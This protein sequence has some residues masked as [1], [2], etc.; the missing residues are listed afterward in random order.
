MSFPETLTDALA[1]Q[2]SPPAIWNEDL[3]QSSYVVS[4]D[5]IAPY[6][7]IQIGGVIFEVDKRDMIIPYIE[8]NEVQCVTSFV[9]SIGDDWGAPNVLGTPFLWNVEV[10][11]DIRTSELRLA[12]RGRY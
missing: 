5:A 9:R 12:S 4:C 8:G 10:I 6:F 2:Y 3:A 11:H 7:A 1:A